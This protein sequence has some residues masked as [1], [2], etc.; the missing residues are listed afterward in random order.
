MSSNWKGR[1]FENGRDLEKWLFDRSYERPERKPFLVTGRF[2]E[3]ARK[4]IL[5]V[6]EEEA[7]FPNTNF[8]KSFH[9]NVRTYLENLGVPAGGLRLYGSVGSEADVFYFTDALFYISGCES[10]AS[11]DSFLAKNIV[12]L[13][14]FWIE[15]SSSFVFTE[16]EF[17]SCIFRHKLLISKYLRETE[18]GEK[19]LGIW[20]LSEDYKKTWVSGREVSWSVNDPDRPSQR[21]ENHFLLTQW[22][23]PPHR[24]KELAKRIA[25]ALAKQICGY[26]TLPATS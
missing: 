7:E 11:L 15:T 18:D 20:V 22:H 9:Y 8:S 16:E 12:A 26:T 25:L 14:D 4:V 13:R 3:F 1:S 10:I 21:P 6:N 24:R 5:A 2:S 17:Q 23:L 19:T